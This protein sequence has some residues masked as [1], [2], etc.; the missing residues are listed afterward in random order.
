MP[1]PSWGPSIS[2]ADQHV[3]VSWNGML[4][5]SWVFMLSDSPADLNTTNSAVAMSL[6][7]GFETAF[8]LT[9]HKY[10]K[11]ARV[12]VSAPTGPLLV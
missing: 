8:D 5:S 9:D 6:R 4:V 2:T 3:Y 10:S 12:P 7:N 11:Y 1:Q